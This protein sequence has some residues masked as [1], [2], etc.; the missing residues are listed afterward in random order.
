MPVSNLYGG[1]GDYLETPYNSLKIGVHSL[2][3]DVRQIRRAVEKHDGHNPGEV[4][5]LGRYGEEA[6]RQRF[7]RI[8]SEL[9]FFFRNRPPGPPRPMRLE[10]PLPPLHRRPYEWAY[11]TYKRLLR[12]LT[13]VLPR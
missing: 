13:G 6:F 5:I 2:E 8:E 11:R 12:R 1:L 3:Y 4:E 9:L 7:E 10:P